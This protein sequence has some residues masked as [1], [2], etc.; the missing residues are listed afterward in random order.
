[1]RAFSINTSSSRFVPP[2]QAAASFVDKARFAEVPTFFATKWAVDRDTRDSI[3]G[4]ATHRRPLEIFARAPILS[5]A[6][7]DARVAAIR[8]LRVSICLPDAGRRTG[9]RKPVR[10]HASFEEN[11]IMS[12]LYFGTDL[13]NEFDRMQR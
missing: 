7:A 10:C 1:M 13:F 5:F 3:D 9:A 6:Q 2:D 8:A 12:D 4:A 11:C